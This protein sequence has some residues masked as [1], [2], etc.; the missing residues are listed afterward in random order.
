[1]IAK[2]LQVAVNKC[3]LRVKSDCDNVSRIFHGELHGLFKGQ[4]LPKQGL[5]RLED[6]L[7]EV[8]GESPS[9]HL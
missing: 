6:P 3:F 7:S 9:R 4:T 1:M 2:I 8:N 5:K